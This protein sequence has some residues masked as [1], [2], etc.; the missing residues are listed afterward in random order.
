M[1]GWTMSWA[2]WC[3]TDPVQ[4][5]FPYE[6]EGDPC[7]TAGRDPGAF[8]QG[9]CIPYNDFDLLEK[10]LDRWGE[11]VAIVLVETIQAGGVISPKPGYWSTSRVCAASTASS[12][13]STRW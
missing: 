1:A 10:V 7:G 12:S 3:M 13:A 8:Q 4:D 6:G 2:G 5:P 9:F 11:Q